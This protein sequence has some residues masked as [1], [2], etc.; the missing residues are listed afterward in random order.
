MTTRETRIGHGR[1]PTTGELLH[2]EFRLEEFD[3][4]EWRDTGKRRL[5]WLQG[6][7]WRERV[8]LATEFPK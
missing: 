7:E 4:Q 1:H 5:R 2:E 6:G 3:G 8:Y